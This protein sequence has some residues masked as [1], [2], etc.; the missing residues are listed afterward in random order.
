MARGM[1]TQIRSERLL[2]ESR[3]PSWFE[4]LRHAAVVIGVAVIIAQ[5]TRA[6]AFQPFVI[7]SGSMLPTIQL[8][9]QVVAERITYEFV[10]EPEAGDIVVFDNPDHSNK[11]EK[12]FIKRVIAVGGQT[13]DIRDGKVW[14]DG[15][16][17]DEPYTHGVVTEPGTVSVPVKV[18]KGYVWLMGD[19]RPGSGDSRYFGSQPTSAIR[20]R[21]VWTYW[22]LD[23]FGSLD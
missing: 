12:Y 13:V 20:A 1:S 5:A 2:D 18:P 10:R 9:D 3:M 7:P 17:L 8:Y 4:T 19:N 14:V 21:A 15:V 16:A 22:P 23:H 11:R 6:F